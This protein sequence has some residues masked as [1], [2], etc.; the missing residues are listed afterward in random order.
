MDSLWPLSSVFIA[1]N[2]VFLGKLSGCQFP[3]ENY[4]VQ[5]VVD[6]IVFQ[7]SSQISNGMQITVSY[8][9]CALFRYKRECEEEMF[10]RRQNLERKENQIQRK[11]DTKIFDRNFKNCS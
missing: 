11:L 4:F 7:N 3:V 6:G 1:S 8:H 10:E 5:I 9:H 2:K